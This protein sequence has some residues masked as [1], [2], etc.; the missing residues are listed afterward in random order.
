L[1]HFSQV[2]SLPH[3]G[4]GAGFLSLSQVPDWPHVGSGSGSGS[5]FGAGFGLVHP[6]PQRYS[7]ST[8]N[9]ASSLSLSQGPPH[10]KTAL[11]LKI[12][13]KANNSVIVFMVLPFQSVFKSSHYSL[14]N[15]H[16]PGIGGLFERIK[17][18]SHNS[19]R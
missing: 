13:I 1:L 7:T 16:T 4:F 8:V 2:Q 18:F 15:N 17:I 11:V 5:G 3:S 14:F 19:N 6:P 9:A 10:A 12:I